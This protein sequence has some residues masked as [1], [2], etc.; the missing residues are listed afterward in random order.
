M[1]TTVRVLTPEVHGR[2]EELGLT[3]AMLADVVRQGCFYE[4]RHSACT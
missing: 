2:L 4:Y 1:N 3:A